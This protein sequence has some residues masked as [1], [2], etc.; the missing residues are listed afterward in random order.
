MKSSVPIM[1]G[2]YWASFLF[3]QAADAVVCTGQITHHSWR[4]VLLAAGAQTPDAGRIGGNIIHDKEMFKTLFIN[5]PSYDNL[6]CYCEDLVS[7]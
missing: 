5:S 1:G 4:I 2:D 7:D 3:L 6:A